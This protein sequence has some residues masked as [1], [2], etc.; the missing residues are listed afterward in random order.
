M[1]ISTPP[2]LAFIW[3]GK[4]DTAISKVAFFGILTFTANENK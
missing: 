4:T 3:F 2:V 1:E